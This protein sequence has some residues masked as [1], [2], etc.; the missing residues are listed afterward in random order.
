MKLTIRPATTPT[1]EPE[2]EVEVWLEHS[3]AGNIRV[4][5]SRK[6]KSDSGGILVVISPKGIY[7]MTSISPEIGF[8]LDKNRCLP[9]LEA[10]P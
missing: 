1:K 7:R 4:R 5:A 10:H 2:L 3:C 8:A 6:G 9:N